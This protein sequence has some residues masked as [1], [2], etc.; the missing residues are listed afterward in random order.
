MK[1]SKRRRRPD[2]QPRTGPV[3]RSI[4]PRL[5]IVGHDIAAA[6]GEFERIDG[7][8]VHSPALLPEPGRLL[9]LPCL[10][11]E[12][13]RG[14][15]LRRP[16]GERARLLWGVF[17]ARLEPQS[18]GAKIDFSR[19]FE[20]SPAVADLGLGEERGITEGGKNSLADQ[21][22]EA[23]DGRL[24]VRPGQGNSVGVRVGDGSDNDV[25][26]YLWHP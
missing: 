7:G 1:C 13:L 9:E 20:A 21:M 23:V 10:R 16:I 25:I 22:A 18:I 11:R 4:F 17:G 24:A 3:I 8:A 5:A 12:R 6:R 15:M 19:P 26:E 14:R 2:P